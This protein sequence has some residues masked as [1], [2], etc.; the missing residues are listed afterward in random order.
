MN[1]MLSTILSLILSPGGAIMLVLTGIMIWLAF[2]VERFRKELLKIAENKKTFLTASAIY[3]GI[4]FLVI[5]GALVTGQVRFSLEFTGGT[6]LEIGFPHNAEAKAALSDNVRKAM[7]SFNASTPDIEY[8]FTVQPEGTPKT[9]DYPNKMRNVKITV[10]KKDGK[11]S[12]SDVKGIASVFVDRFGKVK[13]LEDSF[14]EKDGKVEFALLMEQNPDVFRSQVVDVKSGDSD[15]EEKVQRHN[16]FAEPEEI[17]A[18]VKTFNNDLEVDFNAVEIS[19]PEEHSEKDDFDAAFVKISKRAKNSSDKGVNLS[20]EEVNGILQSISRNSSGN[21]GSLYLFKKESIGPSIGKE[22]ATNAA[23]ALIVALIVQLIY[24]TI[25]FNRK[26]YYGMA[27][28]IGLLHDLVV[29]FGIYILLGLEF[30]SPF[31]SAMMTIIGYSVMNSIV[32]FDRIREDM[33]LRKSP[34]FNEIVN[35]SCSQTMT[36][37]VN[38]LITVLMTLFALYLF[39]GKTLQSFALALSVGCIAGGY[40]SVFLVP[41]ILINFEKNHKESEEE[42]AAARRE[43]LEQAAEARRIRRKHAE[44]ELPPERENDIDDEENDNDNESSSEPAA[45]ARRRRIVRRRRR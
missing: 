34:D 27:A 10:A 40:S 20:N 11:A 18:L 33:K 39:G 30:D 21:S 9:V 45:P 29:M 28:D 44:D 25:R 2:Y 35:I 37:S 5:I 43:R 26:W 13:F 36:R 3:G 22:L 38:T 19:V 32:I 1:N 42:D 16:Y 8:N 12:L 4:L 14:K 24:I 7:D 31:V 15:K 23:V 17:T 41:S 6:M